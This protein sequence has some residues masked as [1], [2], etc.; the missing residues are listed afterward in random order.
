MRTELRAAP[1]FAGVVGQPIHRFLAGSPSPTLPLGLVEPVV[2]RN[3]F[4]VAGR[5]PIPLVALVSRL[6]ETVCSGH[7]EPEPR[8]PHL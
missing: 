4:G 3:P 1:H 5:E 2:E 8:C 6:R 7:S